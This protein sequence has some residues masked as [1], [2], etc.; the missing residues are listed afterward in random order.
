[1]N[2]DELLNE[3]EL[4]FVRKSLD[5]PPDQVAHITKVMVTQEIWDILSQDR[6]FKY[7]IQGKPLYRCIEIRLARR[8]Y[9]NRWFKILPT[10]NIGGIP[11]ELGDHVEVFVEGRPPVKRKFKKDIHTTTYS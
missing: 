1:M 2:L 10:P 7:C 5:I 11:I 3:I 9:E 6:T 4:Q 8:K